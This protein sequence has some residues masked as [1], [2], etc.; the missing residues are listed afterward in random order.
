MK[1]DWS[2]VAFSS[3]GEV[4]VEET[5]WLRN[6][7]NIPPNPP[8]SRAH[9]SGMDGKALARIAVYDIIDSGSWK[10]Q[11]VM[12]WYIDRSSRAQGLCSRGA[13]CAIFE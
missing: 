4:D 12:Q 9:P 1:R 13:R 6:H 10:S 2:D 8:P 7:R 5:R 11:A 3:D